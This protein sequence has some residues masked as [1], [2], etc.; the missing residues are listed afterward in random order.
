MRLT[1][2]I[3]QFT[4]RDGLRLTAEEFITQQPTHKICL[5]LHGAT[6]SSDQYISFANVLAQKGI[7]MCLIDMRG[8]GDSEGERGAVSYIGQYED[9]LQDIIKHYQAISKDNITFILGGHSS[10]ATVILKHIAKLEY[11][12]AE[13]SQ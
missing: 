4:T 12:T 3:L 10:G 1:Y 2:S 13:Q 11:R 7:K 8:H 6:L 5:F 9:D